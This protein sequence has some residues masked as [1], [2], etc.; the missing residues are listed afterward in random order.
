MIHTRAP[1]FRRHYNL[2]TKPEL[3]SQRASTTHRVPVSAGLYFFGDASMN[4]NQYLLPMYD[5]HGKK[6]MIP[7]DHDVYARETRA[8]G[9]A[10][11]QMQRNGSCYCPKDELIYCDA[12]CSICRHSNTDFYVSLFQSTRLCEA[13]TRL[14]ADRRD[15]SGISTHAPLRS[16]NSIFF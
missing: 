12:D 7:V 11:K 8:V 1:P 5:N 13:R 2:A 9:R 4:N 10:R 3:S 16:A 15:F 6:V 14:P